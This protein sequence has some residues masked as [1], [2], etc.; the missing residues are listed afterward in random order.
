L[1]IFN[2]ITDEDPM[3]LHLFYER[4]FLFLTHC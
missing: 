3:P 1:R 2:G 4:L